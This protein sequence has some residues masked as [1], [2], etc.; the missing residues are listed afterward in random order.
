V[1]GMLRRRDR[2][3]RKAALAVTAAVA[4]IAA[5]AALWRGVIPAAGTVA[6]GIHLTDEPGLSINP[7]SSADG[8]LMA[9]ASDRVS[10]SGAKPRGD[11]NIWVMDTEKKDK[12]QITDDPYD[13]DEPTL[14]GDGKLIAWRSMRDDT[15]YVRA[16]AGGPVRA[17]AKPGLAPRLSP[18]GTHIAYYSGVESQRTAPG[19]VWV[20][21]TAG[22]NASEIAPGFADARLPAWSPD[23]K[24]ILFRGAREP[25][26]KLDAVRDWWI[27]SLDGKS[28]RPTGLGGKLRSALLVYHESPVV[29]EESRI[30]FAARWLDTNDIFSIG[31]SSL[32][33]SP[34]GA[35]HS[36][37]SGA[38]VQITPAVL[39]G[40]R[41]AYASW[42]ENI[43]LFRIDVL[44]GTSE[45]VTEKGQLLF[46]TKVSSSSDGRT[47]IFGRRTGGIRTVLTRNARTREE[48]ELETS[49]FAVPFVS[50]D[51]RTT[52]VSDDSQA[53]AITSIRL[54]DV[55]SGR[56][57][58]EYQDCG[59]VRGWTPDSRHVLYLERKLGSP[60]A[61]RALDIATGLRKTLL[62]DA[63]IEDAA[64]APDGRKMAFTIRNG[65][66]YSILY[67]ARLTPAGVVSPWTRI[68][69]EEGLADKPVWS[70]DAKTIY[71]RARIDGFQCIW[72]QKLDP[73]NLRVVGD[74]RAVHHFHEAASTISLSHLSPAVFS[75]ASGGD[76]LFLT[77]SMSDC[78]LWAAQRVK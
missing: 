12:R 35:P 36:L 43:Q 77:V 6:G 78:S 1:V 11:L 60:P 10:Q 30:L 19:R 54:I 29:W 5:G 39:S 42:S 40:G 15:I 76:S 41:I 45:Q 59:E 73:V 62:T 53:A 37:V 21:P 55:S 56:K 31:F 65:G 47:L 3:W 66:I 34:I 23:G 27:A 74:P 9:Y 46:N 72:S 75:L 18:D 70:P 13:E 67:V 44:S 22:G 63:G 8:K 33:N 7:A 17:V 51:G 50:P 69:V 24:S 71:F 20:V 61:I 28:I 68:T 26:L 64:I 52:A 58:A 25:A 32:L 49:E 14:S 48:R 16:V 4:C 57:L 2:K 38:G